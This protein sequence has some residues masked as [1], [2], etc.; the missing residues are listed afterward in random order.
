MEYKDYLSKIQADIEKQNEDILRKSRSKRDKY[1]PSLRD[2]G[3]STSEEQ[4][5]FFERLRRDPR[6]ENATQAKIG[7]FEK[8]YTTFYVQ[9]T[10]IP[11]F[12]YDDTDFASLVNLLSSALEI[13]LNAS[14]YQAVRATYGIK[15]PKYAN[16]DTDAKEV[17][18]GGISINIGKGHQMYGAILKLLDKHRETVG[19]VTSDTDAFLSSL[20]E[21]ALIRNNA[22]HTEFISNEMFVRFYGTFASL[23]NSHISRMLSLKEQICQQ[24]KQ[25]NGS[26]YGDV[27]YDVSADDYIRSLTL[28]ASTEEPSSSEIFGIILTDTRKISLKYVGD[29]RE[30]VSIK[31]ELENYIQSLKEYDVDYVLIDLSDED[32]PQLNERSDW[33]D[34]L[35]I[36]DGAADKLNID[37]N[38]PAGLFIIG[39]DDVVPMPKLHNPGHRLTGDADDINISDNT[40]DTDLPYAYPSSAIRIDNEGNL[41][42]EALQY[43]IANPRFYVGRLPMENG[44]IKHPLEDDLFF[45][46]YRSLAIFRK[47]GLESRSPLMTAMRRTI[48]VGRY[49]VEDIP[50]AIHTALPDDMIAG[51]LVTSPA[52]ALQD[53]PERGY[54]AHGIHDY[55]RAL[56]QS[57]M[58]IFLLHGGNAPGSGAYVGDF[59]G[60]DGQRIMPPAFSPQLLQCGKIESIATVSCYGARFIGYNREDST[61]LSAIYRDT[62]LFT[63]S[64]RSAYGIFDEMMSERNISVPP[65]SVRMMRLYLHFLFAGIRGAE[66]LAKAKVFYLAGVITHEYGED[67]PEGM[68]TI[69]E[70]NYFGDP[71]LRMKPQLELYERYSNK[72]IMDFPDEISGDKWIPE[73]ELVYSSKGH[74]QGLLARIRAMVDRNYEKIHGMISEQLYQ[75]WNL[76]PRELYCVHHYSTKSGHDG[77]SLTYRH[78]VE[79]IIA[80]TIVH[81]DTNGKVLKIYYSY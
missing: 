25:F 14:L 37:G 65:F 12:C 78:V 49:M 15:M 41:S 24:K 6:L 70:F 8:L 23:F 42:L 50:V 68:T 67:I 5:V 19:Y 32:T 54:D 62:V 58:L 22:D 38:N 10:D 52:L 45:Y 73:Y 79:G 66:A 80:E 4:P 20:Q 57:D 63:G 40:I 11:M 44:Y 17:Y 60:I 31:R 35:D 74:P 77:Y 55:V 71:L 61:L 59:L 64:S 13:E 76:P 39:G 2:P 36:L 43:D 1:A 48:Q 26:T 53:D 29:G 28:N 81:T 3:K 72:V 7:T 21:I 56:S 69:Q 18:A 34:Y 9:E 30:S 75:R 27:K 16:R 33:H 47:G 46:L 51:D